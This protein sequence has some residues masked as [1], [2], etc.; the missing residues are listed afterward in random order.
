MTLEEYQ[1]LFTVGALV[2]ILLAASP[3]VGLLVSFPDGR[4]RFS[5]FWVL[6]PNHMMEEYPFNVEVNGTSTVFVGVGN[7]LGVSSYYLVYVKFRNQSQPLPDAISFEP[8]SLPPLYE[9]HFVVA[10]DENWEKP[11]AFKILRVERGTNL[12]IVKGISINDVD[13]PV[14]SSAKWDSEY[15]GFYY[16]LFFELWFYNMTSRSLQYHERFVS[17]WLNL[18]STI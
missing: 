3:S 18:T 12:T 2:L 14:D 15:N 1:A 4:Q 13:F 11:L 7:H 9:F 16:Q 10:E 5:E 8:S 17:I 6:G